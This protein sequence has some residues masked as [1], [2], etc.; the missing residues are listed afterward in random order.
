M[1]NLIEFMY[2]SGKETA[3]IA[4]KVQFFLLPSRRKLI[5]FYYYWMGLA[6]HSLKVS[7]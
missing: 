4:V 5:S 1:E 6:S 7:L 3:L 2:G